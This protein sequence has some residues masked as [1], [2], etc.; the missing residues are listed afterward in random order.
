MFHTRVNKLSYTRINMHEL[1]PIGTPTLPHCSIDDIPPSGHD[2]RV[3][4]QHL[5]DRLRIRLDWWQPVL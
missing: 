4:R 5:M 3:L 2:I 1:G